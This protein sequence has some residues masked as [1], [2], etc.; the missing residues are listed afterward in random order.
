[1]S[2]PKEQNGAL[3]FSSL[4]LLAIFSFWL[5]N[6][7][8]AS[9]E[10]L[11]KFHKLTMEDPL[12]YDPSL[13]TE[14]LEKSLSTLESQ[15]TFFLGIFRSLLSEEDKIIFE[16]WRLF[17]VDFLRF[18]SEIKYKTE[19]FLGQK[20][21][22]SARGL[23]EA[24]KAAALLYKENA[25]SQSAVVE[26][27][28]LQNP[29]NA[30]TEIRFIGS[31]TS[32]AVAAKDFLIIR[33]NA[34]KLEEE[35][36][37]REN[38]LLSGRCPEI[39]AN[40]AQK[41]AKFYT[42]RNILLPDAAAPFRNYEK[43]FGPYEA[44][45]A[46]WGLDE[47][48]NPKI[49]PFYVFLGERKIMPKLAT[50]NYYYDYAKWKNIWSLA[51]RFSSEGVE[52]SFQPETAD[53]EC[54]DLTYWP[55]ILNMARKDL[56][57]PENLSEKELRLADE[58]MFWSLPYF[59]ASVSDFLD[60]LILEQRLT[61]K[62]TSKIYA[63]IV[64]TDY[65]IFYLTFARSVWRIEEKPLFLLKKSLLINELYKSY[66]DLKSKGFNAEAIQKL[67]ETRQTDVL[68]KWLK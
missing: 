46:C 15:E 66:S 22:D 26:K 13:E 3:M 24:Y 51:S 32:P 68:K 10:N 31:A 33:R 47:N 41:T 56:G 28:I 21:A 4:I 11:E 30:T 39:S 5:L 49:L 35:V 38:C 7:E 23:L 45:S 8:N 54:A 52:Y 63:A 37:A 64:R 61:K 57:R 40:T 42:G 25:D 2:R 44:E 67:S 59:A 55:R 60:F 53:Y 17:P 36:S 27:L 16:K 34:K 48:N 9:K 58:N 18:L 20:S 62:P 12:F 43:V 14:G 1:M 6:K 19:L 50:E 29:K 65:S